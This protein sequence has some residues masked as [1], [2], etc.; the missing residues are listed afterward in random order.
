[1]NLHYI[2]WMFTYITCAKCWE[3]GEEELILASTEQGGRGMG[4]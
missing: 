4:A 2:N 3:G 1:M